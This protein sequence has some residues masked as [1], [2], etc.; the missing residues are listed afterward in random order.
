MSLGLSADE[1]AIYLRLVDK[2]AGENLEQIIVGFG[3][4]P[5]KAEVA[6]KSMADRGIIRVVSNR[7]EAV[8]PRVFLRGLLD[9][10]R[11]EMEKQLD[12]AMS[13]AGELEK[14]LEPVYVEGRLGIRPEEILE[15]LRDLREM[16]VVTA[17]IIGNATS[18]IDII[19]QTFGW[20]EKIRE[21]FFQA[22]ER[23]VKTR[24]LMADL[25]EPAVLRLKELKQM[26]VAIRKPNEEWHPVRG[27]IV[28]GQELVF[29]IW[30]TRKTEA[31]PIYY[32]PHYTKNQGLIRIF[33]DAFEMRWEKGTT[34]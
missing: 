32:R 11:S 17:R 15:P 19:A 23:G 22:K 28:D 5:A 2:P 13:V 1:V 25:D 8:E 10:R 7:A 33:Q 20:Y 21:V 18:R 34:L 29:L 3:V 9:H 14:L 31:K 24:V 4:P 16:E 6:L 12:G 26:G 30:A 27:T